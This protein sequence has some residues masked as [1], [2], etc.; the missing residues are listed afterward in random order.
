MTCLML[1]AREGASRTVETLLECGADPTLRAIASAH[2]GAIDL[3]I[4]EQGTNLFFVRIPVRAEAP[5]AEV[6]R[7]WKGLGYNRRAVNMQRTAQ[8]VVECGGEFPQ[9]VEGETFDTIKFRLSMQGDYHDIGEVLAAMGSLRRIIVPV[10]VALAPAA[11]PGR[12]QV[13][14]DEQVLSASFDLARATAPG[15]ISCLMS[16]S[17]FFVS[18]RYC[19]RVIPS[20]ANVP[21][22]SSSIWSVR[23]FTNASA[24]LCRGRPRAP[25]RSWS[26]SALVTAT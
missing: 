24:K 18:V 4:T 9:T 13:G 14:P 20:F 17:F 11:V 21:L 25:I 22:K 3:A 1:A 15:F 5:T 2:G 23:R 26:T 8:A 19:S 7:L 6:I 12:T 16:C 10:N